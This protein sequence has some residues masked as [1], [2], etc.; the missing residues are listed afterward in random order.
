MTSISTTHQFIQDRILKTVK[1]GERFGVA[2]SGGLDSMTLLRVIWEVSQEIGCVPIVLH[3]NHKL[4]GQHS[5]KDEQLVRS[6]SKK[7]GFRCIVRGRDTLKWSQTKKQCLEEAARDLRYDFFKKQS[8]LLGVKKIFLAHHED[9]LVET[10]LMRLFRGTGIG[11]FRA[12]SEV[13][14]RL[15]LVLIRPLLEVSRKDLE[16]VA[17]KLKVR[18]RNDL[19][20]SDEKFLRNKIRK[21]VLP[22]VERELGVTARKQFLAFRSR[23]LEQ[24]EYL[25]SLTQIEFKA[26]WKRAGKSYQVPEK[27]FFQMHRV[28]QYETLSMAYQKLSGKTLEKKEWK[29]VQAVLK[30]E[31]PQINLRGNSFFSRKKQLLKVYR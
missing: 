1:S 15:G 27:R 3:Y 13:S 23:L 30:G 19:T 5:L 21:T 9:D 12:M 24:R 8:A 20:N 18:Y 11:G 25:D 31:S 4:R 29:K 7:Y 26:S 16:R 6:I 22:M 28:L 14:R 10:L 17:S 2:V